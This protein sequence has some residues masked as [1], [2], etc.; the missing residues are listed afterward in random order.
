M[1]ASARNV[2]T[3]PHHP[4]TPSHRPHPTPCVTRFDLRGEVKMCKN[5]GV[6]NNAVDKNKN[7]PRG[8][9]LGV[10]KN[11]NEYEFEVRLFYVR[12][13]P[14]LSRERGCAGGW[15]WFLMGQLFINGSFCRGFC[16][17]RFNFL[18]P[19]PSTSRTHS[20]FIFITIPIH[21]YI[22]IYIYYNTRNPHV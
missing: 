2:I 6:I 12:F 17:A 5:V 14:R 7:I 9:T 20:S 21:I 22:I 1:C 19:S 13:Y 18:M 3:P 15:D 10:S 4:L 8:R 11:N 16:I